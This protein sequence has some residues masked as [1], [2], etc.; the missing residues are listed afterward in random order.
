MRVHIAVEQ[1]THSLSMVLIAI[2]VWS[3]QENTQK[4][5][6]IQI[7]CRC[8]LSMPEATLQH[9]SQMMNLQACLKE[10]IL[11]LQNQMMI[12]LFSQ[13]DATKTANPLHLRRR[14]LNLCLT[15]LVRIALPK[16]MIN[17]GLFWMAAKPDKNELNSMSCNELKAHL[18]DMHDMNNGFQDTCDMNDDFQ[19]PMTNDNPLD[20]ISQ[21]KPHIAPTNEQSM[22]TFPAIAAAPPRPA[23]PMPPCSRDCTCCDSGD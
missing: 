22:Q 15:I 1:A 7:L 20:L 10:M 12:F 3:S 9:Q 6:E 14:H 13:G 17:I 18:C 4:E 2:I 21:D 19:D 16:K 8:D 11:P 23:C 5:E